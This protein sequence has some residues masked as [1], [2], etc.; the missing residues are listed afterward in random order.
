[1]KICVFGSA[2]DKIDK[3]YIEKTYELCYRLAKRGHSLVFGAGGEGLM[4]AAARGFR[5]GGGK[6]HGVIPKFFDEN[7]YEAIY[8][9]ADELTFTETMAERKKIMEDD[10]EA[11]IIVPGGIGTFEEFFEILTLKQLGRH[12]KA[13][14]VYNIKG[15]YDLMSKMLKNS[16]IEKFVNAECYKLA[17][18]FNDEDEIINYVENYSASD[19][20]WSQLKRNG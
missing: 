17:E 5:D 6:I 4:G 2:S 13:I 16:V 15:Y 8:R 14:A 18:A 12:S 20:N 1:M 11:F 7:G 9:E 19:V 3:T 10:C